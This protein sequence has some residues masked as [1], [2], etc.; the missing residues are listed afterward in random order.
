VGDTYGIDFSDTAGTGTSE[1][2]DDYEEGTWTPVYEPTTGS[3]T[4][5]TMDVIQA[6]YTKIG[7]TVHLIGYIR[8]D[9]VDT[10]GASGALKITGLPFTPATTVATAA[11][12]AQLGWTTNIPTFADLTSAGIFLRRAD[13]VGTVFA[14]IDVTNMTNAA[15]SNRVSFT[16][17]YEV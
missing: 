15:D 13:G 17:T 2:L 3:F 14:S 4:S 10:T 1:L 5:I 11:C 12:G 9:A 8:T 16:I 7:D 6:K